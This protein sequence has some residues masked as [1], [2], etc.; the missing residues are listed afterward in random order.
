M[1]STNKLIQISALL[2]ERELDAMDIE[3][4]S[5]IKIN[6]DCTAFSLREIMGIPKSVM[7]RRILFLSGMNTT[8]GSLKKGT[9]G[10]RLNTPKEMAF[11]S[12][13][14]NDLNLQQ[15]LLSLTNRGSNV[16]TDFCKL[17]ES[18]ND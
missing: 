1:I 17:I 12:A 18:N 6:P 7:S 11:I 8:K 9:D 4:L 14:Q 16:V 15:N 3:I 13:K 2:R 10:K 5:L